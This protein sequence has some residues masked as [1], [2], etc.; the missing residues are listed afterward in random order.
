M[1]DIWYENRVNLDDPS[2]KIPEIC[3][4]FQIGELADCQVS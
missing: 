2:E 3:F 4:L 1:P